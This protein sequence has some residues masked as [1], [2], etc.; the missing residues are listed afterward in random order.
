MFL[1]T[2]G[3]LTTLLYNYDFEKVDPETKFIFNTDSCLLIKVAGELDYLGF[4][5]PDKKVAL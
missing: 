1:A 2:P 3:D 5:T 4:C